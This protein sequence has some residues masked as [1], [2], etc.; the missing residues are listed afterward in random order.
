MLD[1]DSAKLT[2]SN[3]LDVTFNVIWAVKE[4]NPDIHIIKLGT[5]GEYGTP[6]ID[7]EEG[8]SILTIME[9]EIGSFIHA[10]PGAFITLQKILDTDLLWFYVRAH[11]LKVTDLMQGPVYG[12]MTDES[13]A[14]NELLRTFTM[15][16]Y[17]E[18]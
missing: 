1:Y 10:K 6:N 16:I 13:I 11:G 14:D 18:Q 12:L 8:G 5:M 3:N 15:T 17:L 2:L 7:I 9:E 4:I